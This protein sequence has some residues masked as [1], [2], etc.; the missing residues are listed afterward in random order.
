MRDPESQT[1]ATSPGLQALSRY[2]GSPWLEPFPVPDIKESQNQKQ[3]PDT[4]V[5]AQKLPRKVRGIGDT[6]WEYPRSPQASQARRCSPRAS[7]PGAAR[8]GSLCLKPFLY[9]K[10]GL[11]QTQTHARLWVPRSESPGE[12]R[13]IGYTKWIVLLL[14]P[15]LHA[16]GCILPWLIRAEAS[17][18]NRQKRVSVS[19]T[20]YRPGGLN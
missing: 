13:R 11:T 20:A 19:H 7:T 1:P 5:S 16:R 3:A 6:K 12:V 10:D 17:P 18:C 8:Y 15:G 14:V 9:L 2:H 4:G